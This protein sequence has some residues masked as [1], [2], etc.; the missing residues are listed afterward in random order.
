MLNKERIYLSTIA[1]DAAET[2]RSWGLNLEIA[3]FC[4]AWNMDREFPTVD[5]VVQETIRGVGGLLL[6]APFNELF[7]CAIDP[8]ARELSAARFRQAIALAKNYGA[9]KVILHGGYNPWIYYPA[10]YVEQSILFWK[11]FLLDDPGVELVL[12]NVL[13][14]DPTWLSD[15]VKGVNDP[16]LRMCLDIGHVNAYSKVPVMEW[17]ETCAPWI[18]HFHIHNNDGTADRHSALFEGTIPMTEF[19][20]RA[21][22]LCPNA[23]FTLELMEDG[24]S[25]KWLADNRLL[26]SE[27]SKWS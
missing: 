16:R 20:R 13:E 1:S 9:R 21:E 17:L 18:S 23:T 10:W 3:E 2:A 27:E 6:H 8:K 4:T 15:I 25:V 26:T 19:L 11:D 22:E 12:E 24:P 5:R 7:P 14:T